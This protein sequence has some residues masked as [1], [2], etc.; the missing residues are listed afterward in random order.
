MKKTVMKRIETVKE[1]M[2]YGNVVVS[3]T[4]TKGFKVQ[5]SL[6]QRTYANGIDMMF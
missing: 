6:T 1:E 5:Y 3:A 4:L 2:I